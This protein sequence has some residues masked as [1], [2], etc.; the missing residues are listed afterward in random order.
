M[1]AYERGFPK[2]GKQSVGVARQ[3]GG[4]LGKVGNGQLGVFLAYASGRGHALVDLR[5]VL[6][7]AWTKDPARCRAAGVPAGVG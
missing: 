5:L 4:A 2:Q 6:P 1:S 3:Y 7:E